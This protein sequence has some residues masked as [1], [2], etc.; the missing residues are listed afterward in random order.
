MITVDYGGGGLAIDYLIKKI[1]K[2]YQLQPTYKRKV[3]ILLQN[4]SMTDDARAG[5]TSP[6]KIYLSFQFYYW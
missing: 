4:I 1:S 6:S 5:E 3:I 2:F